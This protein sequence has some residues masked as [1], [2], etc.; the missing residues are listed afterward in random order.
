MFMSK[1]TGDQN[2]N[3]SDL[4]QDE[5]KRRRAQIQEDYLEESANVSV[6]GQFSSTKAL[7][8]MSKMVPQESRFSYCKPYARKVTE[9]T[10]FHGVVMCLILTNAAIIGYTS[11]MDI[12]WHLET[13]SSN[14]KFK[15]PPTEFA[16]FT[17]LQDI[18]RV[19]FAVELVMRLV[20]EEFEFFL[21]PDR[22]RNVFDAVVV[23]SSVVDLALSSLSDLSLLRVL[24]LIR[25]VRSLRVIRVLRYAH[26]LRSL[27]LMMGAL[28]EST[29]PLF[30]AALIVCLI[31]YVFAVIF[32][33]AVVVYTETPG[34]SWDM[35]RF[36]ETYFG[37]LPLAVI[38]LF[39][40]AT[41][42]VSWWEV[43]N[44]WIDIGWFYGGVFVF[45]IFFMVL[46]AMNIVTGIF[47][48]DALEATSRDNDLMVQ[49]LVEQSQRDFEDLQTLFK[50]LNS[51]GSDVLTYTAF[52]SQLRDDDVKVIF[53]RLGIDISDAE[54]FFYCLDVDNNQ[55]LEIDE[56][57]M[58]C[59][60]FKGS[61][62]SF[63]MELTVQRM[64]NML[65]Q[66]LKCHRESKHH[67]ANLEYVVSDIQK[68]LGAEGENVKVA[69][70]AG[71]AVR[72]D[73]CEADEDVRPETSITCHVRDRSQVL[74]SCCQT[75]S[76]VLSRSRA[77][78]TEEHASRASLM[79]D[80]LLC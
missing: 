8:T 47:V 14:E 50:R 58:G 44:H 28:A 51:N 31:T 27:R 17:R 67:L 63:H 42:G 75:R 68:R 34:A 23:V 1:G 71:P 45:Y 18:F 35:V 61:K 74:G 6:K 52:A 73:N 22:K 54:S 72:E 66:Q 21:G 55:A 10:A 49:R 41:G 2:G 33:Q 25:V 64:Q 38:T 57:V 5:R 46:A 69:P 11:E 12:K 60:R 4:D 56:F 79:E 26:N 53:A 62:G 30:W 3:S 24:R 70:C 48:N 37:T 29:V 9:L 13:F 19:L 36:S 7:E 16:H 32:M 76:P 39:S 65:K 77:F 80:T 59:I 43:A 40:A 20:A 78:M 15:N